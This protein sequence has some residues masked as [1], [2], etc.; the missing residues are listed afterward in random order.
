MLT[1][2]CFP[3]FDCKNIDSLLIHIRAAI[4]LR[5]IHILFREDIKA[6]S[7]WQ[8]IVDSSPTLFNVARNPTLS[9]FSQNNADHLYFSIKAVANMDGKKRWHHKPMLACSWLHFLLHIDPKLRNI[10]DMVTNISLYERYCS[11]VKR[12]STVLILPPL[13]KIV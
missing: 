9:Q 6:F 2:L 13:I 5:T 3:A 7:L 10:G 1:L 8:K 12:D 4:K 11:G